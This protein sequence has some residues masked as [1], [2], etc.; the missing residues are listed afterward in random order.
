MPGPQISGIASGTIKGSLSGADFFSPLPDAE[1][2]TS[3][4]AIMKR[5]IPPAS[6]SDA[7]VIRSAFRISPPQNTNSS[8]IAS[9]IR[10]SRNTMNR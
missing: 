5:I 7:C 9:A 1:P 10:H 4:I 2:N 6:S 3:L 8:R